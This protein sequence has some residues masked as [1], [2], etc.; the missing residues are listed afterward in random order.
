MADSFSQLEKNILKMKGVTDGQ[1]LAMAAAGINSRADFATIGDAA[2]LAALLPDLKPD[3]A[4]AVMSWALV[5]AGAPVAAPSA[6]SPRVARSDKPAAHGIVLDT[7]EAVSYCTHCQTQ[8]SKEYKSGDI[9][10]ACGQ[11]A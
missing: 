11:K 7:P 2:T 8:Q 4:E 10:A 1:L 6:L 5:R 3:V 9:C